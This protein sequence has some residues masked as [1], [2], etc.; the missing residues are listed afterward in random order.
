MAYTDNDL[1]VA[2]ATLYDITHEEARFAW[3]DYQLDTGAP[4][5][6][7]SDDVFTANAGLFWG[8][9]F[10]G[11]DIGNWEVENGAKIEEQMIEWIGDSI[12]ESTL[13]RTY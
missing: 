3:K 11:Q 10:E 4:N 2:I 12:R 5:D 9:D 13:D 1:T 7:V 6:F 8:A